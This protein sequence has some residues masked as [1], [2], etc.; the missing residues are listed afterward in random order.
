MSVLCGTNYMRYKYKEVPDSECP[1]CK[2]SEVKETALYQLRCPFLPN[3]LRLFKYITEYLNKWM[4][5]QYKEPTMCEITCWYIRGK[6]QELWEN[7]QHPPMELYSA[8]KSQDYIGWDNMVRGPISGICNNWKS[9]YL[10]KEHLGR[11]G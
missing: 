11:Q 9:D 5:G 6:G 2:W 3:I 1:C 4:N 10:K 7:S 8:E